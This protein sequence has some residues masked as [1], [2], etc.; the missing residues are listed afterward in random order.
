MSAHHGLFDAASRP[1]SF[2]DRLPDGSREVLLA[3]ADVIEARRG[4]TVFSAEEADDRVGIVLDGIAR[5]YI[6]SSDGRRMSV[7]YARPGAMVGSITAG[8][9]ALS[10]QAVTDCTLV[11]LRMGTLQTCLAA[12]PQVGIALIAEIAKRLQD[13]YATLASNTFGTMRERVA[14]HI[15]DLSIDERDGSRMT[16]PITQQG[17]A[18][19]VGTVR[20]VVARILRAFREEGL[21]ATTPGE[22]RILDA[23]RLAAIVGRDDG[24]DV[25]SPT[26]ILPRERAHAGAA[27]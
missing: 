7:R 12:D 20:E 8:R 11:E 21:I 26:A 24:S 10:V 5:T 23:E 1:G 16:A 27:R 4:T 9:A 13:T 19:G 15:L 22:I 2:L 17:L 25:G 18:D 3:D 6:T 14:R